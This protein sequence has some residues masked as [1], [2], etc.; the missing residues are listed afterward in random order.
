MKLMS[1][2]QART[3]LKVIAGLLLVSAVQLVGLPL[4]VRRE[5]AGAALAGVA[6]TVVLD[7]VAGGLLW[8]FAGRAR[9]TTVTI[10]ATFAAVGLSLLAGLATSV[11]AFHADVTTLTMAAILYVFGAVFAVRCVA[12][13]KHAAGT[14]AP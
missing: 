14:A 1:D 3:G 2:R 8:W 12:S 7:I 4:L 11:L 9:P 13:M 6:A 10:S 5:L